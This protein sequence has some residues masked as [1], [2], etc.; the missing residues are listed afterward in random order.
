VPERGDLDAGRDVPLRR[1]SP[2]IILP[3]V[4]ASSF[5]QESATA[6][7]QASAILE[8]GEGRLAAK[9][10]MSV[11]PMEALRLATSCLVAN[12]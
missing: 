4:G 9:N 5:P 2:E 12:D 10:L 3:L 8:G 11:P 1:Y 6:A 7:K